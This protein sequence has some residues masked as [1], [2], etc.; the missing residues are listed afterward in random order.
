[1]SEVLLSVVVP[2]KDRY[3]YLK[4]F[5]ELLSSFHED[6]LELVI[7]DNS[8][9]N[10]EFL[11]WMEQRQ[12]KFVVY[13]YESEKLSMTE[14]SERGT[15]HA[16]GKYVCF[17]GDDDFISQDLYHFVKAME[18]HKWEA[19]IFEVANYFWPGVMHKAHRFPSLIAKPFRGILQPVDVIAEKKR[20][21][22]CGARSMGRMP[23]LY[24]GVVL[25]QKLEEIRTLTG[26]YFPGPSP[27]M[28]VS[29]ALLG[30]VRRLLW[31]DIPYV[32]AGVAP[33][34]SA[35]MGAAHQHKGSLKGV[36]WLPADV[37]ENWEYGVPKIW[38]APTIWAESALKALRAIG[39]ENEIKRFNYVYTCAS[40]WAFVPEY[41]RLALAELK[42][43]EKLR[44]WWYVLKIYTLRCCIF[45]KNFLMTR[46]GL[47]KNKTWDHIPDTLQAGKLLDN[48]IAEKKIDINAMFQVL[49][50]NA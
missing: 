36:S 26:T 43:G 20:M 33:K 23:R 9:D 42:S 24:H 44:F 13:H 48:W 45:A 18:Q 37:E 32:T 6:G 5:V 47:T 40:L 28:A 11:S 7:Q 41:R 17:M 38:T 31:C 21:L 27:D 10:S 39:S 14:N 8:E 35:A 1:M 3:S 25:R 16:S 22:R 29:V 49:E 2:T 19:A 50:E 15:A 12:D 34:S 30:N 4:S 46:F